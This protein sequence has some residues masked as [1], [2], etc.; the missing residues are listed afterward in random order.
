MQYYIIKHPSLLKSLWY[1][2]F[3]LTENYMFEYSRAACLIAIFS[4]SVFFKITHNHFGPNSKTEKWQEK[5]F[6][7]KNKYVPIRQ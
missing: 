3:H 2:L 5:G 7:Q 1:Q 4:I 6:L